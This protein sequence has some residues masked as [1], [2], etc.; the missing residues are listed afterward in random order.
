M[1]TFEEIAV[2]HSED[3][4]QELV[5]AKMLELAMAQISS[6]QEKVIDAYLSLASLHLAFH[7]SL[8]II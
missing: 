3:R 8:A 6:D 5:V 7:T 2:A 4:G 1:S